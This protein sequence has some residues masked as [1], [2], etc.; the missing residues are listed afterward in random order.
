MDSGLRKYSE[1]DIVRATVSS[2]TRLEGSQ[3]PQKCHILR[4]ENLA[5]IFGLQGDLLPVMDILHGLHEV[6]NAGDGYWV[7]APSR[8]IPIGAEWM[9][10]SPLPTPYLPSELELI[11]TT[12]F[13]RIARN[14]MVDTPIQELHDW[15]G[16]PRSLGS[17]VEAEMAIA[18][19]TFGK[20]VLKSDDLQFYLPWARE[21]GFKGIFRNWIA[22]ADIP[23]TNRSDIQLARSNDGGYSKYYWCTFKGDILFDSATPVISDEIVRI[24]FAL[25]ILRGNVWR[26]L[27]FKLIQEDIVFN[28][29]FPLPKEIDRLLQAIGVKNM[30]DKNVSY[31]INKRYFDLVSQ[32]L[33]NLHIKFR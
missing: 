32:E 7:P 17:W 28:C 18:S 22:G 21:A 1:L 12:G 31:A 33:A 8:S 9:I 26:E 14:A 16:A 27:S 20:T 2:S 13:A 25:E 4:L 6:H 10:I 19:E 24:Q 15:L 29:Y 5:S 11:E 3:H 23:S 30:K